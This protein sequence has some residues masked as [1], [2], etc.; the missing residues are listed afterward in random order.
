MSV[1][2]T[3]MAKQLRHVM[4]ETSKLCQ[5]YQNF[6]S[7]LVSNLE[8]QP[9][10]NRGVNRLLRFGISKDSNGS[11][12]WYPRSEL[13]DSVQKELNLLRHELDNLRKA[14]RLHSA[15]ELYPFGKEFMDVTYGPV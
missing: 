14:F 10:A 3:V 5:D 6:A 15:C 7:Y 1:L 13:R 11:G 9:Q 2:E 12:K 8:C 4:A